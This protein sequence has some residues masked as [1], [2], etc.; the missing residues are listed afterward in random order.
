MIVLLFLGL[1]TRFTFSLPSNSLPY[2]FYGL[3]GI[4]L[5]AVVWWFSVTYLVS[6]MR[7]WFNARGIRLLNRTIGAII[8]VLAMGGIVLSFM[9]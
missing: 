4:A 7:R 9:A 1:F 5:G 2:I 6:K 3:G 8:L